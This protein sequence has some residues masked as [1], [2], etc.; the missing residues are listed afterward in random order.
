V[1]WTTRI[2]NL[3]NYFLPQLFSGTNPFLGVRPAAR[4][5]AE[6]QGTGFVW[7][8]SGYI[9]LLWGGGLPL[10]VTFGAFVVVAVR[11]LAPWARLHT[12]YTSVAALASVVGVVVCAALMIFDP[13]ITYRGSADWLFSL[14]AMS[15]SGIAAARAHGGAHERPAAAARTGGTFQAARRQGG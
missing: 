10:L 9:W 1:S 4:V 7:I 11:S 15:T 3:E 5:V 2:A 6:H 13:H 14:L 8:E 12:S